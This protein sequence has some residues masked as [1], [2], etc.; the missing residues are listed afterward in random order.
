MGDRAVVDAVRSI[1]QPARLAFAHPAL[2]RREV[3]P[4][5]I[6]DRDEAV[7]G[8]T[9][10]ELGTDEG[11]VAERTGAQKCLLRPG[12]DDEDAV[13]AA[14]RLRAVYCHLGDQLV[15]PAADGERES[16][17]RTNAIAD[18]SRSRF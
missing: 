13:A 8:K 10:L 12:R 9:L 2:E 17:R 5:Q 4:E 7:R 15:R 1:P 11:N 14:A 16:S 3:V 18:A 6:L